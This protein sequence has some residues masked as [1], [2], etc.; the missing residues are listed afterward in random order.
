MGYRRDP[1]RFHKK[2]R[3]RLHRR[4][5][6]D[7]STLT[8]IEIPPSPPTVFRGRRRPL[9]ARPS[10]SVAEGRSR[11]WLTSGDEGARSIVV[12]GS[13]DRDPPELSILTGPPYDN[14][15]PR[16]PSVLSG[17]RLQVTSVGVPRGDA[18]DA[19]PTVA[20]HGDRPLEL[21]V[22]GDLLVSPRGRAEEDGAPEDRAA[23][24]LVGQEERWLREVLGADDFPRPTLAPA[25]DLRHMDLRQGEAVVASQGEQHARLTVGG[26]F[27]VFR[28]VAAIQDGP[29]APL[30]E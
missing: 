27:E 4:T 20:Q 30:L 24:G 13:D 22:A 18:N 11:F 5:C 1:S 12:W 3:P 28:E 25:V 7:G 26:P 2:Q 29:A 9:S 21:R 23:V 10:L 6:L 16:Q 8:V 19:E 17:E 15:A 14:L